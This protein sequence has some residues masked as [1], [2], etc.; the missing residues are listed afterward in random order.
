MSRRFSDIAGWSFSAT[1][2]FALALF[3]IGGGDDRGT[4]A[5]LATMISVA[6]ALHAA[7]K[8]PLR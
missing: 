2:S 1:W 3:L 5:F 7:R 6:Y 8:D 4:F